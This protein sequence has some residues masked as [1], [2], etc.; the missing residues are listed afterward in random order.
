MEACDINLDGNIDI[1]FM[2][3]IASLLNNGNTNFTFTDY[4]DIPIG[5]GIVGDIDNDGDIDIAAMTEEIKDTLSVYKNNGEEN[6]YLDNQCFL[7]GGM[8]VSYCQNFNDLNSD[9]FL[10][11]VTYTYSYPDSPAVLLNDG[12]GS[13]TVSQYYEMKLATT[14][15]NIY[16][17]DFDGDGDIDIIMTGGK[18]ADDYKNILL[19]RGDGTFDFGEYQIPRQFGHVNGGD[20]D[21]DGDIDFIFGGGYSHHPDII[22]NEGVIRIVYND[23][24]G[25]FQDSTEY[26]I[27]SPVGH[28]ELVDVDQDGD[29]DILGIYAGPNGGPSFYKLQNVEPTSVD[30]EITSE[31]V[32]LLELSQNFPNP[33][34]SQTVINYQV[35]SGLHQV[36]LKIYNITGK[37]VITLVNEQL[38]SGSY[39][40][41]W[42]GMNAEGEQV[43]SGVYFY[44]LRAGHI[45]KLKKMIVIW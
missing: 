29:L 8:A 1:H 18:R 37:E 12:T 26:E 25:N 14:A 23:G 10:D 44:Y 13:F 24:L 20:I 4:E 21:G 16:G 7:K 42:N 30:Q 33:F 32:E 27:I 28:V 5:N 40:N 45:T 41:V 15:H 36:S 6:F 31:M 38:C 43:S 11:I 9:G 22:H 17:N 19:N 3:G 2:S 34:N 39:Q 35:P